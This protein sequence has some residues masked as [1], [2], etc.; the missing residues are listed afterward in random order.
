MQVSREHEERL[1]RLQQQTTMERNFH[2][3][4]RRNVVG[5]GRETSDSTHKRD[6]TDSVRVYLLDD[7]KFCY[8]GDSIQGG[9]HSSGIVVVQDEQWLCS[10]TR[11]VFP[12]FSWDIIPSHCC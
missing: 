8:E 5:G 7:D 10:I 1:Q 3:Q 11:R 2:P 12:F 6:G 4:K 9:Q